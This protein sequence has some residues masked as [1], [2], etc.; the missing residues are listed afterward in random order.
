MHNDDEAAIT[1]PRQTSRARHNDLMMSFAIKSKPDEI[2]VNGSAGASSG[3]NTA[4]L[5]FGVKWKRALAALV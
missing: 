5:T 2:F 3:R 1:P 4:S